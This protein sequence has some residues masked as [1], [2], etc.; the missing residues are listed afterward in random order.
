MVEVPL[1]VASKA[2]AS[3]AFVQLAAMIALAAAAWFRPEATVLLQHLGLALRHGVTIS[4]NAALAVLG[5][6][7]SWSAA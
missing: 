6:L 5:T 3:T 7:L 4:T 1:Q 2:L